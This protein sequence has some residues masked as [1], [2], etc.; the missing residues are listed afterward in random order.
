MRRG[1]KENSGGASRITALASLRLND[2]R[3]RLPTRR[4]TGYWLISFSL[5]RRRLEA[6]GVP[7]QGSAH[8]AVE[9]RGG[10]VQVGARAQLLG[11][12]GHERG[13]AL[14]HEEHRAEPRLEPP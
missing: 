13:L 10:L 2:S 1:W 11:L 4:A 5:C 12:G 8:G 14:E 9:Q 6:H 3:R 7:L